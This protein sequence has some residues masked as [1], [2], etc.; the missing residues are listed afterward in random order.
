MT[1]LAVEGISRLVRYRESERAVWT[2]ALQAA[3]D[4]FGRRPDGML[5]RDLVE[6]LVDQGYPR[7]VAAGCA[8]ELRSGGVAV[9]DWQTGFLNPMYK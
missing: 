5:E 3:L 4:V 8:N 6:E 7:S 9:K 2:R 1:L